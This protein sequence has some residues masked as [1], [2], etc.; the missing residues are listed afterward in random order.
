VEDSKVLVFL[1][2]QPVLWQED[3]NT[4]SGDSNRQEEKLKLRATLHAQKN[5][6]EKQFCNTTKSEQRRSSLTIFN[7]ERQ[8]YD[9]REKQMLCN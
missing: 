8:C 2:P 1:Q 7:G 4:A 3:D 6:T 9:C 5:W